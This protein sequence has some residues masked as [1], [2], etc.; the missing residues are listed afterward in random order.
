MTVRVNKPAV[1]LREELADLRKPTGIA[2][3]AMLRAE[4]PQ[5]QFNLIGA[6][7]RNMIING[8]MQVSQRGTSLTGLTGTT[9]LLDR[10]KFS[11]SSHGAWTLSQDTNAPAGFSKS[12]KM[13]CTSADSSVGANDYSFFI[14]KL[15]GNEVQQLASGTSRAKSM[16]LSFWVKSNVSGTY[17]VNFRNEDNARQC[18]EAYTV[19][20]TDAWEYKT[21]TIPPD[22]VSGYTDDNALSLQ[23]EWWLGAGSTFSGGTLPTS[24]KTSSN[25]DRAGANTVDVGTLT[26]GYFQITGV[27][28]ELGKVAT[29]FEHRSYGEE[30]AAC[31]RYLYAIN[32]GGHPSS[33]SAPYA[34]F[35]SF[36]QGT[37]ATIWFPSYPVQMRALPS[38]IANNVSSSTLEMF[39]Y[40]A[41]VSASLSGISQ[42]EGTTTTGQVVFSSTSGISAGDTVSVRWNN[43][44]NASFQFDAEL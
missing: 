4:T 21:V 30:L 28:L 13:L 24:W 42:A 17:S 37:N 40:N 43:N 7:R 6:G 31:Q 18:G 26:N 12:M 27:Q 2:G 36:A 23:V 20:N 41:Q 32:A 29:P 25:S 14:Y 16:T 19:D 3:E 9:F 10:F 5:E 11:N 34:R 35:I 22:T 38:L 1:N 39:N 15:E 33:T 8:A 44:P